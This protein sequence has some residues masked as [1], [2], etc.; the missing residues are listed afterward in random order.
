M[1]SFEEIHGIQLLFLESLQHQL[2]DARTKEGF[3]V[4][5]SSTKIKFPIETLFEAKKGLVLEEQ[6]FH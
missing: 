1:T 4:E 6:D 3:S 5:I 2:S